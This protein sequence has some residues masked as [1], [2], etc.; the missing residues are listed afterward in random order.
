MPTRAGI[1]A[2]ATV[3]WSYVHRGRVRSEGGGEELY[4]LVG[5]AAPKKWRCATTPLA[6]PRLSHPE[7][8]YLT[9]HSYDS[10]YEVFES[11]NFNRPSPR[12]TTANADVVLPP[13]APSLARLQ[14]F[15]RPNDSSCDVVAHLM[16]RV[17]A[18][19]SRHILIASCVRR[20]GANE[21][22]MRGGNPS[23]R[24]LR[25]S[26]MLEPPPALEAIRFQAPRRRRAAPA[27]VRPPP[28]LRVPLAGPSD[29]LVRGVGERR[30][31]LRHLAARRVVPRRRRRCAQREAANGAG[32]WLEA[33]EQQLGSPLT[34]AAVAHLFAAH[35]RERWVCAARLLR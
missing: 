7:P 23:R 27:Y 18:R 25:S 4:K 29:S 35:A 6:A 34:Q 19:S 9:Q 16:P 2:I 10:Y 12:S 22:G 26:F 28:R 32:D 14:R 13:G 21:R 31:R 17:V 11:S 8:R 15:R 20:V 1:E 33:V 3:A 5:G 24:S 30:E